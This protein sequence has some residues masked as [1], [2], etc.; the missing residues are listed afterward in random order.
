MRFFA[1]RLYIELAA[2]IVAAVCALSV[3]TRG[4]IL[5]SKSVWTTTVGTNIGMAMVVLQA[6]GFFGF[7]HRQSWPGIENYI[8][9]RHINKINCK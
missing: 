6:V 7:H 8:T 5:I 2:E 3:F 4:I 9:D 1:Y